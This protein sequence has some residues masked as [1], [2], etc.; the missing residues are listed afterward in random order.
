MIVANNYIFGKTYGTPNTFIG[1]VASIITTK[2]ILATRLGISVANIPYFNI[3]GANIEAEINT[4]YTI[5]ANKF[6]NTNSPGLT[7][8]NDAGG[9]C[10]SHEPGAFISNSTLV[11][12]NF[13]E[14]TT[15][16]NSFNNCVNLVG[17]LV[18]PKLI[19]IADAFRSTKMTS[20]SAPLLTTISAA[21]FSSCAECLSYNMPELLICG[22]SFVFEA[23][24]KVTSIFMPKVTRIGNSNTQENSVLGGIKTGCQITVPIAMQTINAGAVEPDLLTAINSRGAIVTYV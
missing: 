9:R 7:Y 10:L 16:I 22:G 19:S 1:G 6:S 5:Q 24:N 14:V 8:Y 11:S 18:F 13:P 3:I 4:N 15:M 20:F 2:N 21:G 17:N 23:N 12:I